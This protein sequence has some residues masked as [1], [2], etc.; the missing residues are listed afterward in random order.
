[1]KNLFK[2]LFKKL[3]KNI[4]F[5]EDMLKTLDQPFLVVDDTLSNYWLCTCERTKLIEF[6]KGDNIISADCRLFVHLCSLVLTG[7][8]MIIFQMPR[9]LG[10]VEL[11]I[12]KNV[13]Y[14]YPDSP[15]RHALGSCQGQFLFKH[16]KK[17]YGF[18]FNEGVKAHTIPQWKQIYLKKID[19]ICDQNRGKISLTA[20]KCNLLHCQIKIGKVKLKLANFQRETIYNVNTERCNRKFPYIVK[21]KFKRVDA[22][23]QQVVRCYDKRKFFHHKHNHQGRSLRF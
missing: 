17:Y 20:C 3:C 8:K 1:M 12:P 6:L 7:D 22:L 16:G 21:R 14:L 11:L 5:G 18:F 13:F 15:Y 10:G 19:K 23:L 4:E 9:K 2:N